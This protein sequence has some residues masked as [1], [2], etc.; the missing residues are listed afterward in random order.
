MAAG[1]DTQFFELIVQ[2]PSDIETQLPNISES[3]VNWITGKQW[4]LPEGSDWNLDKV[5]QVQLT[6][7][8]KIQREIYRYWVSITH[9]ENAEFFVQLEESPNYFHL[10]VLLECCGI[11]PLVLGRYVKHLQQK[12][13]STVYSGHAPQIENWLRITKTKAVGGSNKMRGKSYIPA[14]LI[15]KVQPEVH[16]AWTN[17]PEYAPACLNARL[18]AEIAETHFLEA[19]YTQRTPP[20][21]GLAKNGDGAPVILSK[22]SRRYMELVDWLVDKGITTEKQWLTEN[23]ESY[24]SFQASGNSARQ[25]KVALQNAIQEMLLTKTAPDYLIGRDPPDEEQ[26]RT[27]NRIYDIFQRN[28]YDP[29]YAANVLVGW[30]K[31]AFNKRNTVWLFGPATTGKTNIAEAIA[32]AVPFYGCVNWTNENF[33]FND[34]L[35]KM[36]IWWEEGKM[37]AKIVESAKAILGGSRVRVDQKCKSSEE[38]QPTPVIITSNTNMCHVIDGNST[39]FEHQKPLEDR[40]FLFELVKPLPP[41]YGKV[42]KQEVL[43]FFRWGLDH[44]IEVTHEFRVPKAAASKRKRTNENEF[45]STPEAI[46]EAFGTASPPIRREDVFAVTASGD[47]SADLDR[48]E[49]KCTKHL[50]LDKVRFYC[51]ACEGI[52]RRLDVCFSHGTLN[53]EE[54]FPQENKAVFEACASCHLMGKKPDPVK[55]PACKLKNVALLMGEDS[56]DE[57][58]LVRPEQEWDDTLNEQ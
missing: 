56:S 17:I 25:I 46:K 34:C 16:W 4:R 15:P 24:R 21:G 54:C 49:R 32:H 50:H 29:A 30:C 2:L 7:G 20:E 52:N 55:C 43:D 1:R 40:M 11:K 28:G 23:K 6:L 45:S 44:P 3:F 53:C 9:N 51:S 12:L 22:A 33:P 39:T 41:N 10:H 57:S 26:I 31:G 19:G 18:R 58:S 36:I 27:S 48:Y 38:I 37:T 8:D 35:N 13:I 47:S 42:T 5:D 14:Y